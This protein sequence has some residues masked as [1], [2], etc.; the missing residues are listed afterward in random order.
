MKHDKP[1]LI[2]T[3][4]SC[5]IQ[6][7][8]SAFLLLSGTGGAIYGDICSACRQANKGKKGK[9]TT[10]KTETTSG[11]T[12]DSKVK[13]QM[14]ID[15]RK[16]HQELEEDYHEERDEI[17]EKETQKILKTE[18]ISTDEKKHRVS[19][20]SF[21]DNMNKPKTPQEN[22][23]TP[24]AREAI[25]KTVDLTTASQDTQIAGKLKY[26]SEFL[27][28]KAWLGGAAP[29]ARQA[30]IALRNKQKADAE[31]HRKIE[32]NNKEKPSGPRSRG[33]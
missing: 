23:L 5:G 17:A 3:C 31:K 9:E 24:A 18:K 10:E 13:V 29:I 21:I 15:K 27:K 2:K 26:G 8:L 32:V 19:R 12:I 20:S 28:V 1:A 33:K 30:E 7:P 6:K 11:I 22:L 4:T 14:D 16:Q 25:E